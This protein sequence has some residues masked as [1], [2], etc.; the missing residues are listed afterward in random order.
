M[1]TERLVRHT[2]TNDELKDLIKI[3]GSSGDWRGLWN[4]QDDC[5]WFLSERSKGLHR[6]AK[7]GTT[8]G[9]EF[10]GTLDVA[11]NASLSVGGG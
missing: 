7:G 4:R 10:V 3:L 8:E 9:G 1:L 6:C 2:H 11:L 5:R